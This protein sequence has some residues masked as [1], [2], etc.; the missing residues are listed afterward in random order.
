MSAPLDLLIIGAGPCGLA[1]AISAQKAGLGARILDA[2]AVVSTITQYPYY[3]SFF[4][5]A[6]KL[7]LGGVPFVVATDK[8]SRRDGLAYYRAIVRHFGLDVRQYE[9]VTRIE[10]DGAA[11]VVHSETLEGERRAT[12]ARAVCVATGYF[13]SPNHLGVP[14]EELP[15]VTHV[16]H[17]GHPAFQ[18]DVVV[19]GGGNSAAEAAL[20]LWRAGA[21]VTLVHFGPTFDKRIKPWVLPDLQNRMNEGAIG[22]RWNSRVT[23][24]E[25]GV[26]AL[27]GPSGD[28]RL[29]A[30]FVY[31][32][33]GF[34]PNME[35][36]REVGVPVNEETGIPAHDPDTL[37]T[38]VPGLFIAGVVVAGYDANK[39]FIENGRFH[40]DKIVA[41][42]L[43]RPVP[44]APRLSAELDT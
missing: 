1:A 38:T 5:T 29:P 6:E 25:P 31:V 14:G 44:P 27:A 7:S 26:V 40:G 9:R 36:L 34:A 19:V 24:I 4:S 37:E 21:R 11:F 32:M 23:A 39:V 33:T 35:L 16:Y 15:H 41:R 43:G 30:R 18:Q 42:L 28:D 10:P 2:G 8:P 20:D 12:S 22:A 13:G 17:E 3:V